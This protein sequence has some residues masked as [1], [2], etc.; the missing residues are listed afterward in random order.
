[1]CPFI[2]IATSTSLVFCLFN[3]EA[4]RR[5]ERSAVQCTFPPHLHYLLY[6]HHLPF[7]PAWPHSSTTTMLCLACLFKHMARNQKEVK[8]RRQINALFP[9]CHFLSHLTTV[10]WEGGGGDAT[11]FD[12]LWKVR[13]PIRFPWHPTSFFYSADASIACDTVA[14]RRGRLLPQSL[15]HSVC[16]SPVW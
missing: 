11:I 8:E 14:G 5:R 9:L 4:A 10:G 13:E 16:Y 7:V 3:E 6:L 12:H 1:M 15:T 2:T